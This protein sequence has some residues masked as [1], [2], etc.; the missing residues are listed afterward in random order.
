M[1][2]L[3]AYIIFSYILMGIIITVLLFRSPAIRVNDL[4][5][6]AIIF[7]FSPITLILFIYCFRLY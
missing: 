1:E 3:Y 7:T 5:A 4:V 6:Y 2:Y